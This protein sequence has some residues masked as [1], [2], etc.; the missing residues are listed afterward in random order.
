[1][2]LDG[3]A[4]AGWVRLRFILLEGVLFGAK[5]MTCIEAQCIYKRAIRN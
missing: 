5:N 3:D 2:D 1:M 4:A